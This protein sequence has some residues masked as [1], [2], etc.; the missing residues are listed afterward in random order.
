M[1]YRFFLRNKSFFPYALV[2]QLC[3]VLA[4]IFF[5]RSPST[6]RFVERGVSKRAGWTYEGG[7]TLEYPAHTVH[8]VTTWCS[9]TPDS[10]A[11]PSLKSILLSHAQHAPKNGSPLAFHVFVDPATERAWRENVPMFRELRTVLAQNQ[12][13]YSL[14][15]LS[16]SDIDDMV[17]LGLEAEFAGGEG[18]FWKQAIAAL[19]SARYRCNSA[20]LLSPAILH[21][22][23][24]Y[25]YVDYDTITLCDIQRLASEFER[26]PASAALGMAPEFPSPNVNGGW[27]SQHN[28]PTG[29][30]NGLNSGVILFNLRAL[31]TV[32]GSLRSYM[33]ALVDTISAGAYAPYTAGRYSMSMPDQDV[34]NVLS[35]KFSGLVYVLSSS[36]NMVC[37]LALVL[38]QCGFCAPFYVT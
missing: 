18:G 15:M 33:R 7:A 38:L 4:L 32:F 14:R 9:V 16:I 2:V 17:Q 20:R 30:P 10:P 21:R 24:R 22:L 8:I 19:E 11:V 13:R 29:T 6:A 27:Y 28:L 36:W 3:F 1:H 35:L 23:E 37:A 26:F 31:R 12:G 34:L 5:R 25:I